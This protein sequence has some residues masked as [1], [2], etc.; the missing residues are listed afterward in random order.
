MDK[1][2]NSVATI[3][4]MQQPH[5]QATEKALKESHS[6]PSRSR[7]SDLRVPYKFLRLPSN[8]LRVN[9]WDALILDSEVLELLKT[10]VKRMLS[11]FDPGVVDR[12]KPEIEIALRSLLFVFS[13]GL[14]RSTPGMK[15][16]NIQYVPHVLTRRRIG[17]FFML[18]VGIPYVWKRWIR[19]LSFD[20]T[21]SDIFSNSDMS[22]DSYRKR[23]FTVMKK[24]EAIVITCQFVNLLVFLRN[25][26]YRSLS[27]RCLGMKLESVAPLSASRSIN[28]EY[29]NR[30]LLWNGLMDF[31]HFVLPLFTWG[32]QRL[33]TLHRS[34]PMEQ[35]IRSFQC[36]LCGFAPPQT[37][38]ITSCKHVYCYYCLQTSVAMEDEFVYVML[39]ME[40][41]TSRFL[42]NFAWVLRRC[43]ACGVR[44]DTSHRLRD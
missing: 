10:S 38:Y 4:V 33:I 19:Y 42:M 17:V 7:S 13:T 25:G 32:R 6:A 29:L 12:V 31:G 28:F 37:P 15:L 24:V 9:K 5:V 26:T 20:R 11:T 21:A 8:N 34:L 22:G 44:F 35:D 16:E 14:R 23:A 36:C 1:V 41:L 40:Q 43:A 18:S 30:Q 2:T 3:C 39:A 27:E